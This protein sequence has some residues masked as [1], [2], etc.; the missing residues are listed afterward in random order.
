MKKYLFIKYK[1]INEPKIYQKIKQIKTSFNK[2]KIMKKDNIIKTN[3]LKEYQDDNHESLIKSK[4]LNKIKITN[5]FNIKNNTIKLPILK[6]K[7][8][9]N[10]NLETNEPKIN[11]K[12]L[13]KKNI[14]VKK[15]KINSNNINNLNSKNHGS[16]K[17][18]SK[19]G[20]SY[21]LKISPNYIKSKNINLNASENFGK[22][23]NL[24]RKI[25]K[26]NKNRIISKKGYKL[27]TTTKIINNFNNQINQ[28][29]NK[30]IF[31]LCDN[32]VNNGGKKIDVLFEI[33]K[34]VSKIQDCFRKHLEDEKS[35]IKKNEN[36][37]NNNIIDIISDISLSEEELDFSEEDSFNNIEFSFDEEEI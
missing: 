28:N 4:S 30:E 34:K 26:G 25:I 27:F 33:E 9:I 19:Y 32:N 10:N 12:Y 31:T 2:N 20:S 5:G 36:I 15:I 16:K 8:Y 24:E 17:L 23:I 21:N 22:I 18:L 7:I 37:R 1:M 11:K 3:N 35:E 13:K 14:S 29:K 6:R